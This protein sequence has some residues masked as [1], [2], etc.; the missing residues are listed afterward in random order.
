[1]SQTRHRIA[2]VATLAALLL[3]GTAMAQPVHMFEEAPPLELLRSIMVPESQPG[4]SRR[5]FL[6]QP[7]RPA[8]AAVPAPVGEAA[9]MPPA[10]EAERAPEAEP[11]RTRRPAMPGAMVAT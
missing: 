6:G 9:A 3:G 5:I 10:M 7:D 11:R 8:Q 1:M 2:G 4:L